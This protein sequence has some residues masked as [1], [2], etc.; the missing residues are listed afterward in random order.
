MSLRSAPCNDHALRECCLL[1]EEVMEDIS[2]F[3]WDGVSFMELLTAEWV[4]H[5]LDNIPLHDVSPFA[6]LIE[7]PP[8]PQ[9]QNFTGDDDWDP[10]EI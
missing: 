1:Q 8:R 10:E 2:D 5:H 7:L 9:L 3:N 6:E 4:V